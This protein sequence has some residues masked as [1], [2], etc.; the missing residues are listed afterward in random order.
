[1]N[2]SVPVESTDDTD[3]ANQLPF[4][5]TSWMDIANDLVQKTVQRQ[6]EKDKKSEILDCQL[7]E[8]RK[9]QVVALERIAEALCYAPG[10]AAVQRDLK[11]H[12]DQSAAELKETTA[13]HG[14]N[15]QVESREKGT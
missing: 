8:L 1:M 12:W 10:A 11:T 14:I 3:D 7:L 15:H 6:E 5:Y 9:R 13:Q 4:R 2:E